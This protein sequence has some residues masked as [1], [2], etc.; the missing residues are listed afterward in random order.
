MV[1][2]TQNHGQGKIEVTGPAPICLLDLFLCTVKTINTVEN[3]CDVQELKDLFFAMV[4][5]YLETP[6]KPIDKF[7]EEMS[8]ILDK[9]TEELLNKD[10]DDE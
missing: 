1:K 3:I 2:I 8:D 7:L 10:G 5:K 6:S 9:M 4:E